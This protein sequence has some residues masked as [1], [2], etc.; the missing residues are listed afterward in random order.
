MEAIV[1]SAQG[2]WTS[3]YVQDAYGMDQCASLL[4]CSLSKLIYYLP[5]L[6]FSR[7]ASDI[8][9]YKSGMAA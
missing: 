3:V 8:L 7:G 9:A 2:L 4:S 6:A 5:S 1:W